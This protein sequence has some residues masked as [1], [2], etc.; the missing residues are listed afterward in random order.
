VL[1]VSIS[2]PR[3]VR[4]RGLRRFSSNPPARPG[5]LHAD[6]GPHELQIS[7]R[8]DGHTTPPDPDGV[9]TGIEIHWDTLQR[10]GCRGDNRCMTWAA[11]DNIYTTV[12]DSVGFHAYKPA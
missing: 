5:G 11:E 8:E 10:K 1:T 9:P 3:V 6:Q 4:A 7:R 12:D 2:R